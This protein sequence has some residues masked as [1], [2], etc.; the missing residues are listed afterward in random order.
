VV[1]VGQPW[2]GNEDH[3]ER[4]RALVDELAVP[5][6]VIFTGEVQD[7]R[8]AYAAADVLVLPSA[9]PEPFAGVVLEAMAMG[10]PVI[11]TALGG[12]LDQVVDGETGY[13]VPPGD[14]GAMADK[15]R[16][17]C[18]DAGLRRRMGEAGRER[19]RTHFDVQRMLD[20]LETIYAE[21]VQR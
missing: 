18:E 12:S 15:I 2:P 20:K 7:S 14:V 11:A 3:L 17:L 9:Q 21:V 16:A 19:V 10:K 8:P 5:D 13:L 6:R 1:I 4:L